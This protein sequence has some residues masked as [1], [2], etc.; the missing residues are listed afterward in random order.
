[1]LNLPY[2]DTVSLDNRSPSSSNKANRNFG[3][4]VVK[5]SSCATEILSLPASFR[6]KQV[7][8]QS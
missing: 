8:Q 1:M 2:I 6:S 3:N 5:L 7:M 4:W